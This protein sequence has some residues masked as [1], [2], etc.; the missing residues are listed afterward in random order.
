MLTQ[1]VIERT[2]VSQQETF[3]RKE[4]II[5]RELAA[6]IRLQNKFAIIISGVRRSGKSTL[7]KIIAQKISELRGWSLADI[8]THSQ[9]NA[10]QLFLSGARL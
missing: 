1:E 2:V 6:E 7:M 5:L 4:R 8:A 3:A 10:A 9:H